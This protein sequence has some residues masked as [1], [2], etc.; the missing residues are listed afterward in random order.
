MA[1]KT[2]TI[3]LLA[4][5]GKWQTMIEVL[6]AGADAVYVG[7][8]RY[9]MR[10][11]RSDHN[12]SDAELESAV[13]YCHKRDKKLYVTVNNL[14]YQDEIA[15]LE[16]YLVFLEAIDVDAV[17]VQD[18]AVASMVKR[19]APRLPLH[20]SVQMGVA[21]SAT[22]KWLE[23]TGFTRAILSK[24]VARQEIAAIHQNSSLELEYFIHGD[25]CIS[26]TGQCYLSSF[27][28]GESGNRGR[29]KKP[30][31]WQYRL[32][33]SQEYPAG[34]YLA[35]QDLCLIDELASL[36][37][38]GVV[39]L[40]IEGRMRDASYL[41]SIITAY[42]QALDGMETEVPLQTSV[43]TA[44]E[45]NRVRDFTTAGFTHTTRLADIGISGER[46]PAFPTAP[47]PIVPHNSK[48]PAHIN[49]EAELQVQVNELAALTAVLA[50]GVKNVIIGGNGIYPLRGLDLASAVAAVKAADAELVYQ[51]PRV[52]TEVQLDGLH[53][54]LLALKTAGLEK[55]LVSDLGS[56]QLALSQ[57]FS[58]WGDYS[59]NIMNAEAAS[60]LTVQGVE[61]ITASLELRQPELDSLLRAAPLPVDVLV[62]SWLP[63]MVTDFCLRGAVAEACPCQEPGV[64]LFLVDSEGNQYPVV[65]DQSCHNYVYYP[66]K[67]SLL[68][69][70]TWLSGE[71]VGGVR[72]ELN[73]YS[74]EQQEAVVAIYQQALSNPQASREGWQ[75]LSTITGIEYTDAP[76]LEVTGESHA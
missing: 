1:L 25:V 22:A 23:T 21:N 61:R 64:P 47:I 26:H 72:F 46:E 57:G 28:F 29:C 73:G 62:H 56:M 70:L 15:D 27:I 2:D 31:R 37:A 3:E 32:Q 42:R 38:A 8:K 59:L 67:L 20:A 36:L 55:V 53:S 68:G 34:C 35:H 49:A 76:F 33:G 14:F 24:N 39:S 17:I 44:L 69:Q 65:C 52:V 10:L 9:N 16:E 30:C 19:S 40:K 50:A 45:K 11:L 71:G 7:G 54:L 51:L 18:L 41:R 63:G 66:Y 74:P 4:P 60:L 13:A 43:R 58:V 6:A 12:F 75:K 48:F 5:A